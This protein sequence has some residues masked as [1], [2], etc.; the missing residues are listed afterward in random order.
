MCVC[1]FMCM[2]VCVYVYLC[3]YVCMC[4]CVYVCMCVCVYVYMCICVCMC[5][6]V[7]V[8]VCLSVCLCVCVSVCLYVCTFPHL[9]Q[10]G[11]MDSLEFMPNHP[12]APLYI[13]SSD[14]DSK[15]TDSS[16][17]YHHLFPKEALIDI[18]RPTLP[19]LEDVSA[20]ERFAFS[21]FVI[22]LSLL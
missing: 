12:S 18:S 1:A 4:V 5:V 9:T 11:A 2:C 10:I 13:D 7:C 21:L 14:R 6:C 3:V 17:Y 22:F 15:Y 20:L 8:S 16:T 19:I